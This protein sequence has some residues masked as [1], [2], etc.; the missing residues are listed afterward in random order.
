MNLNACIVYP[1]SIHSYLQS[2]L[3]SPRSTPNQSWPSPSLAASPICFSPR[4][5]FKL[6]VFKQRTETHTYPISNTHEPG[7][8]TPAKRNRVKKEELERSDRP[9][10]KTF[11]TLRLSMMT[12][13]KKIGTCNKYMLRSTSILKPII[14]KKIYL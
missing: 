13:T 14:R 2:P 3:S 8:N 5:K 9:K 12:L 11:E 6:P 7:N 1:R 10:A 4:I